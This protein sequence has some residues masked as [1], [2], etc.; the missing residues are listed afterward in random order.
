MDFMGASANLGHCGR[1]AV[2]AEQS[3][4][5]IG[6]SCPQKSGDASRGRRPMIEAQILAVDSEALIEDSSL[7]RVDSVSEIP[8]FPR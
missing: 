4:L 2:V 7:S 1:P 8:V 6:H 5:P 3:P